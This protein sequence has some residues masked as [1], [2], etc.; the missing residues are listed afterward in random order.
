MNEPNN[1][2]LTQ[3][4]DMSKFLLFLIL[5]K[6]LL[7]YKRKTKISPCYILNMLTKLK[8]LLKF[9]HMF[10]NRKCYLLSYQFKIEQ[11]ILLIDLNGLKGGQSNPSL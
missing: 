2:A 5:T 1:K 7:N 6:S 9:L 11:K 3:I 8:N 4:F 10:T